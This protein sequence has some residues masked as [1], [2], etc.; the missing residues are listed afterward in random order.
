[1]TEKDR[2]ILPKPVNIESLTPQQTEEY[3]KVSGWRIWNSPHIADR[4]YREFLEEL[5]AKPNV[6]RVKMGKKGY[7]T[8]RRK[9]EARRERGPRLPLFSNGFDTE[10]TYMYY[11]LEPLTEEDITILEKKGKKDNI[12]M[13]N[14]F[15]QIV[16]SP[17]EN[18]E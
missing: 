4:E 10:W 14:E 12:L 1:M 6:I 17:Q 16:E 3:M 8:V 13:Q 2:S 7:T 11:L 9:H 15:K 18:S 5:G